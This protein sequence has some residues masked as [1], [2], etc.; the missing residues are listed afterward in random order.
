MADES[1]SPA[2][3]GTDRS[4]VHEDRLLTAPFV[5]LALADLAYFTAAGVAIY[6]LPLY[7]TGPVGS[8][9]AGAGL[10]FGAFAVSALVLRPF[11]GRLADRYGRRPLMVGGAVLCGLAMLSRPR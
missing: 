5:R 8:N 9:E 3:V 6:A 10:A 1:Q 7:V 4:T 11:A 2:G